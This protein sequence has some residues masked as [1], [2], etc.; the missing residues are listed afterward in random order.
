MVFLDSCKKLLVHF[1]AIGT[2]FTAR[3]DG[4]GLVDV[5]DVVAADGIHIVEKHWFR[6]EFQASCNGIFD[7]GNPSCSLHLCLVGNT[8]H[9][10]SNGGAFN[11]LITLRSAANSSPAGLTFAVFRLTNRMSEV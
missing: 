1:R 4:R 3:A 9:Y 2:L 8:N 10:I 11:A 5:L 6:I 7:E